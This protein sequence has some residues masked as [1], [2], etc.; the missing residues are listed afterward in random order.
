LEESGEEGRGQVENNDYDEDDDQDDDDDDSEEDENGSSV[1][2]GEAPKSGPSGRTKRGDDVIVKTIRY[3][4]GERI[5]SGRVDRGRW[6]P[7]IFHKL[8]V[9]EDDANNMKELIKID[10]WCC[11]NRGSPKQ[12]PVGSRPQATLSDQH[13]TH[14]PVVYQSDK[15]NCVAFSAANVVHR[16]D[17]ATA[18]L[19]V[20]CTRDLS[21]LRRFSLWPSRFTSWGTRDM[22]RIVQETS[23]VYPSPKED[24]DFVVGKEGGEFVAQLVDSA[25]HSSHA[26]GLNCFNRTLHDCAEPFA[27]T[28]SE[29]N[30]TASCGRGHGC[31]GFLSAYLLY[32]TRKSR[33]RVAKRTTR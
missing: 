17:P 19:L 8:R 14:I 30:L 25:G 13:Y 3:N 18:Q 12:L 22:Y 5:Y 11:E 31:V 6:C 21:N 32:S 28:I 20:Q 1:E 24:M 27:M 26:I 9:C 10:E 4:E 7:I 16:C 29:N 33:S 2:N 15:A 23:G